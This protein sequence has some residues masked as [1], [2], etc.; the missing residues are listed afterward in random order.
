MGSLE[1]T[2]R[3]DAGIIAW[4][5]QANRLKPTSPAP[6]SSNCKPSS[7][8]C[9]SSPNRRAG[10]AQRRPP[11]DRRRNPRHRDRIAK[12]IDADPSWTALDNARRIIKGVAHRTVARLLA[13]LPE[14]STLSNKAIGKLAGLPPIA[15]DGAQHRGN[16]SVQRRRESVRS[17]LVIVAEVVRRHNPDFARRPPHIDHRSLTQNSQPRRTRAQTPRRAQRQSTRCPEQHRKTA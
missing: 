8:A 11:H 5:A 3:I 16:Q 2:D 10:I 12:L 17:S 6:P 9:A 1:K 4:F 7:H 15:N 14:I 13:E